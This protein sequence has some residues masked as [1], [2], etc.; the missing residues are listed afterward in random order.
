MKF[1]ILIVFLILLSACVKPIETE[2]QENPLQEIIKNQTVSQ[3]SSEEEPI[4]ITYAELQKQRKRE[5]VKDIFDFSLL[6][7]NNVSRLN[8]MLARL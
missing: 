7:A 1:Y 8:S 6:N 3:N 4:Q 5:S 2:I